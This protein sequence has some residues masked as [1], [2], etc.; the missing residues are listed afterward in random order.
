MRS[1]GWAYEFKVRPWNE[2]RGWY[3]A[4]ADDHSDMQYM[5]RIVESVE[6][7]GCLDA[8]AGTTSMHDLMVAVTPVSAPPLDVVAVRAPGSIHAPSTGNVLVEHLAHSGRN[9]AIERPQLDAVRL[10]WRFVIEKLGVLP[11]EIRP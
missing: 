5:L 3:A 4:L 2:L 10:F 8:L 7:S 6:N 11:A 1:M 9:D